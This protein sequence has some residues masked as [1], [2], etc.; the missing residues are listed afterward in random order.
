MSTNETLSKGRLTEK[1]RWFF[2]Q[3]AEIL[4]PQLLGKIICHK[5][6]GEDK[7]LKFRITVVEAYPNNDSASYASFKS[8]KAVDFLRKD[9]GSYC[10]FAG[11]ILISCGETN[12]RDCHDNILI[13]GGYNLSNEKDENYYNKGDGN[14]Y[15]FRESLGLNNSFSDTDLVAESVGLWLENDGFPVSQPKTG[16]RINV[17][18][19]GP[20]RFYIPDEQID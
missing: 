4:A 10:I 7:T 18:G 12:D 2:K 1:D 6:S 19:N 15:L 9:V 8:G 13:R 3:S 16:L 14:P 20:L 11:M 17:Q 5:V